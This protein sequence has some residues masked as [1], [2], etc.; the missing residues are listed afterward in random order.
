MDPETHRV[1]NG[2][3]N[4]ALV[5]PMLVPGGTFGCSKGKPT[6]TNSNKKMFF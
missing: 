5:W 6:Q 3:R 1:L 2:Q 4:E